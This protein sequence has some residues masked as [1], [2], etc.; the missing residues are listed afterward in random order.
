MRARDDVN[1]DYFADGRGGGGTG[2]D[3]GFDGGDFTTHERGNVARADFFPTN[4]FDVGG[5]EHRVS[6]FELGNEAFGFDHS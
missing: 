4:E 5:F 1:G 6:C 2:F 3:G